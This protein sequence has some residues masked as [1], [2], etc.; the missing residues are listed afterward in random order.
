MHPLRLVILLSI[1][2]L[3]LSGCFGSSSGSSS[4][5]STS[6]EEIVSIEGIWSGSATEEGETYDVA[7]IFYEGQFFGFSDESG[8]VWDGAYS[9]N[10]NAF[11]IPQL[12]AFDVSLEV[13][14][15]V[16]SVSGTIDGTSLSATFSSDAG[17]TGS[18]QASYDQ[19]LYERET[20]LSDISSVWEYTSGQGVYSSVAIDDN[21]ELSGAD[22]GGCLF[23]GHVSVPDTTRNVFVIDLEVTSCNEFDGD[24]DGL[25][26]LDSDEGGTTLLRFAAQNDFATFWA[27]FE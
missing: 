22:T 26:Y 23:L 14:L 5:G 7:G 16:S 10:N 25:A 1:S 8:V 21:G 3:S 27:V 4:G 6:E 12:F 18:I 24:Y 11:Q 15:N 20:G 17:T 19:S 2:V 13:L 9:I